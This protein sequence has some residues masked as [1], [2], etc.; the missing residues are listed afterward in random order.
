MSEIGIIRSRDQLI[1]L[2]QGNTLLALKKANC[3]K[4]TDIKLHSN[5][6]YKIKDYGLNIFPILHNL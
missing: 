5:V 2:M 3:T 4:S 1:Q 6:V